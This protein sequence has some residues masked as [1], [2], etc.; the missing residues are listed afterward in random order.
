MPLY[1]YRCENGHRYERQEPFGSPTTQPCKRCGSPARRL[2][3]TPAIAFK[4][5]GW[6]K[7]DSRSARAVRS[8]TDSSEA[9][10]STD[11]GG[12]GDDDSKTTKKKTKKDGGRDKKTAAK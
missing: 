6:Y 3:N 9:S 11:G 12:S 10:K 2:L 5:S 7:T 4:G 1:D 8:L